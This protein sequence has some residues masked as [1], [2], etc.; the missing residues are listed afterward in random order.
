MG[1]RPQK[2]NAGT[3]SALALWA[4]AAHDLKQPIQSLLLFTHLMAVTDDAAKRK[5]T[6][7]SMED[8]L[9]LLQAMLA[10]LAQLARLEAG[11][12]VPKIA[13]VSL[14]DIIVLVARQ[15]TA[16]A[17]AHNLSIKTTIG[18]AKAVSDELLLATLLTGLVRCAIKL[19]RTGEIRI[20]SR[21]RSA[22]PCIDIEF[23]AP[24][25]SPQQSAATFLELHDHHPGADA[26]IPTPGLKM[27][28]V[29]G[30]VLGT[31]LTVTSIAEGQQRISITF[32]GKV[33]PSGA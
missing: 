17:I 15:Q 24:A 14:G 28:A 25:L 5:Q 10:E 21:I 20:T 1:D 30:R 13:T 23:E 27:L 29:L 4:G 16:S 11:L 32:A 19:A 31:E 33:R 8:A 26:T 22:A 3:S 9:L 6:S 7:R 2:G 18:R 12:V